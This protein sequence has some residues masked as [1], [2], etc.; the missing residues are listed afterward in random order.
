M[1]KERV[2]AVAVLTAEGGV[3]G[4]RTGEAAARRLE[5]G[6]AEAAGEALSA[7]WGGERGRGRVR[8]VA[9]L[10]GGAWTQEIELSPMQTQGLEEAA[11]GNVLG[12]EAE[13]FS[14]QGAETAELLW[15]REGTREGYGVFRVAQIDRGRTA[16]LRGELKR[17]GFELAGVGH[18]AFLGAEEG[19]W[20]GAWNAAG[21]AEG[22]VPVPLAGRPEGRG[23]GTAAVR[24]AGML[25]LGVVVLCGGWEAAR[26]PGRAALRAEV[27]ELEALDARNRREQ[28]AARRAREE[29]ARW[30]GRRKAEVDAAVAQGRGRR[31]W[32]RMLAAL[33]EACPGDAMVEAIGCGE[34]YRAEVTGVCGSLAGAEAYLKG[35]RERLGEAGMQARLREVRSLNRKAG[36]GPW[37]VRL[38]LGPVAGEEWP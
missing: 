32:G 25:A 38:E 8:R 23:E 17:A 3:W 31:A 13:A 11:L 24:L 30:N 16:A 35:L 19:E 9:V 21:G 20:A 14:G 18:P 12:Y 36:G 29:A 22:A 1:K 26:R 2:D 37:R 5:G 10:D 28:G 6:R 34:D 27:K 15:R 7:A 33:A 4:W